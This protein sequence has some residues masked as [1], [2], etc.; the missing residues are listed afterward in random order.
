MARV[1]NPVFVSLF[2]YGLLQQVLRSVQPVVYGTVM[3][4]RA[5]RNNR[6]VEAVAPF[7]SRIR[8]QHVPLKGRDDFLFHRDHDAL[9]QLTANLV[10]RQR[11]IDVWLAALRA[12]LAWCETN[13]AAMRFLI[14]PEK[15]VVY[16]DKL[17]RFVHVSPIARQC[18]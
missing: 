4:L 18:S 12:R 13:G 16:E 15:H 7:K 11:Q 6:E 1:T 3:R 17:P 2:V 14:I 10:L 9:D 8:F 5:L